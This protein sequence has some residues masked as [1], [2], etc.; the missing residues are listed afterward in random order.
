M[1]HVLALLQHSLMTILDL[2]LDDCLYKIL[3]VLYY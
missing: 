2:A 3:G 1:L